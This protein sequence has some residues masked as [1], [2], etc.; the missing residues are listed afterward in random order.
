MF[1]LG[2][3]PA[4]VLTFVIN[5]LLLAG[6]V[7]IIGAVFFLRKMPGLS[8]YASMS[9]IVGILILMTGVYLKGVHY[10][11]LQWRAKTAELEA[12]IAVIEARVPLVNTVIET[13]VVDRVK[14][15]KVKGDEIVKYID[16]EIIKYDNVCPIPEE[17]V[18]IHNA[19]AL[20][21][22]IPPPK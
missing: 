14:E 6:V 15:I 3:L 18:I 20:N 22:L 21:A 4:A 16:R 13:R 7:I 8:N 10:T 11:E 1:L 12:K 17:V 5:L 2:L 19:A 9:Q